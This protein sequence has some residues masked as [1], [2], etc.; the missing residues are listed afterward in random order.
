MRNLKEE[1]RKIGYE[2][3]HMLKY[4]DDM[5]RGMDVLLEQNIIHRDLKFENILISE[6]FEENGSIKKIAKIT[7]FGLAKSLGNMSEV[8]SLRCGTP[9]TMAP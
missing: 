1:M 2:R 5:M 9:Y 3:Q 7:D 8:A 6:D 4:F